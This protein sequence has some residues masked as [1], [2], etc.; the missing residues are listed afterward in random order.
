M[1]GLENQY[2]GTYSTFITPDGQFI[3]KKKIKQILVSK[4]NAVPDKINVNGKI[5]RVIRISKNWIDTIGKQYEVIEEILLLNTQC[6]KGDGF[7]DRDTMTDV[8]LLESASSPFKKE[9]DLEVI[10]IENSKVQM[11]SKNQNPSD[12]NIAIDDLDSDNSRSP[13][14]T[15][16]NNDNQSS[17]PEIS[18]VYDDD[19]N[20]KSVSANNINHIASLDVNGS[21]YLTKNTKN[22]EQASSESVTS[23]TS[24][25]EKPK[26]KFY[27]NCQFCPDYYA[28]T[29]EEVYQ[30]K[31]EK[32]LLALPLLGSL[33]QRE[34]HVIAETKRKMMKETSRVL[35][36]DDW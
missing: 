11:D 28:E 15:D 25:T 13:F 30:H 16:G 22:M 1:D 34:D 31:F 18:Q 33:D 24:V 29:F 3:S 32:E 26:L 8:T 21:N 12:K 2:D 9:V 20:L 36:E 23:V 14:N 5:D 35:K 7:C 19:N 17:N 27:I 6:N 4:F 10:Q